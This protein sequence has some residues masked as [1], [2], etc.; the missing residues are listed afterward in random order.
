MPVALMA[1]ATSLCMGRPVLWAVALLL[2]AV[3]ARAATGDTERTQ[4]WFP[5]GEKLTYKIY[6]GSIPVA[7]AEVTTGWVEQ[8]GPEEDPGRRLIFIRLRTRSN[9]FLDK[10]YPV[11]DTIESIV[12]PETFLPVS[13]FK[14]LNEG[15]FHAER[16]TIFDRENGVAHF[17][18]FRKNKK[19]EIPIEPDTRDVLTFMYAARRERFP[20]GTTQKFRVLEDDKI[21][22]LWV[23]ATRIDRIKLPERGRVSSVKLEPE[24]AIQGLFVRK[25][26]VTLWVSDDEKRVMTRLDGSAP[27][28]SIRGLLVDISEP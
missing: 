21:Y 20:V 23:K 15:T 13:F 26:K 6:W 27:V 7:R 19:V 17:E 14:A 1:R 22:D 2:G 28:A 8:G 5:V 11:N 10:I 25:G 12:D 16:R 24:A 3:A 18:D 4:L 9:G